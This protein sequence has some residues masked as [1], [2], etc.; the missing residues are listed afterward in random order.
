VTW[1]STELVVN[2]TSF[3]RFADTAYDSK[4]GSILSIERISKPSIVP[5]DPVDFRRYYDLI[6]AQTPPILN[7]SDPNFS[8]EAVGY[9]AQYG[10]Q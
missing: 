7:Q 10:L 6:L 8:G 2:V 4:N 1:H 9:T 3:Q 5:I